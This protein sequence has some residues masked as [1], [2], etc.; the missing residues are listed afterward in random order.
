MPSSPPMLHAT[1]AGVP[2]PTI[3]KLKAQGISCGS[4]LER[5]LR[6]GVMLDD[7]ELARLMLPH[8]DPKDDG[9]TRPG[10]AI[11]CLAARCSS[12]ALV[13]LL[14]SKFDM[15]AHCHLALQSAAEAGRLDTME[16]FLARM[17]LRGELVSLSAVVDDARREGRDTAASLLEARAL[18]L[19]ESI[20]KPGHINAKRL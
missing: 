19:S 16:L 2:A 13:E 20:A 12:R 10:D 17:E 5:S 1:F 7:I 14:L 15:A 18:E 8:L 9:A 11:L 6:I 4:S 3:A